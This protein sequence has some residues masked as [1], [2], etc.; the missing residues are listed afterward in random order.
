M[1]TTICFLFLVVVMAFAGNSVKA[2]Q[3]EVTDP[4][5][6]PLNVRASPNGRITGKV[7]NGTTVYIEKNSTDDN[8][9]A[10]VKIGTYRKNKYV[11][12]GWVYREFIS[13]Y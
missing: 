13:C 4:T 1:K 2:D 9:K 6:T 11:I 12:L 10:W 7:G 8:G 5:G 3:C